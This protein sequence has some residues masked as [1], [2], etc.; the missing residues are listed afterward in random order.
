M[1]VVRT[2]TKVP[3]SYAMVKEHWTADTKEELMAFFERVEKSYPSQGYGTM[4]SNIH[5]DPT[6]ALWH[7]DFS[8]FT[9]CD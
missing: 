4:L 7:A 3:F 1:A 2:P 9:S 6:G 8:R 5:Q